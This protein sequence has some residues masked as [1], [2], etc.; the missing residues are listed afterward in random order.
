MSFALIR[1]MASFVPSRMDVPLKVPPAAPHALAPVRM[2]SS[3]AF[4]RRAY[5]VPASRSAAGD[6][7]NW[8]EINNSACSFLSFDAT[9]ALTL[10]SGSS[11]NNI[12]NSQQKDFGRVLA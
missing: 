2:S 8:R 4:P 10:P 7:N 12:Y 5:K 1:A 3:K 11:W 9:Y 6:I